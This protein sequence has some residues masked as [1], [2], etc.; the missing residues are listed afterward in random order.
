MKKK[1]LIV[2]LFAI[3]V[4]LVILFFKLMKKSAPSAPF[5][6]EKSENV[7]EEIEARPKTGYPYTLSS[8]E[9]ITIYLPE[10]IDPP[11]QNVVEKMYREKK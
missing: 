8:G 7:L 4:L 2:I 5:R 6:G 3:I 11:P 1:I 10:G 9:T